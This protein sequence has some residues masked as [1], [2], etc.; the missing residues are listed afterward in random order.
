[1]TTP[2]ELADALCGLDGDYHDGLEVFVDAHAVGVAILIT[3]TNADE[4]KQ[5]FRAV[6]EAVE[7]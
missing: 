1:M 5:R 2:E 3:V 7:E 6:V 4:T